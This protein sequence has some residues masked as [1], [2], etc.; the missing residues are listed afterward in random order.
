MDGGSTGDEFLLSTTAAAAPLFVVMSVENCTEIYGNISVAAETDNVT[1]LGFA[2]PESLI[3][4][5]C[6]QNRFRG[7]TCLVATSFALF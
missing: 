3:F 6:F 2:P 4:G 7:S 5:K 1:C